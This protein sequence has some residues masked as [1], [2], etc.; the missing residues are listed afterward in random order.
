M[1]DDYKM[2]KEKELIHYDGLL[3]I[4]ANEIETKDL[5]KIER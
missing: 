4:T 1:Q 2:M 3:G 5:S